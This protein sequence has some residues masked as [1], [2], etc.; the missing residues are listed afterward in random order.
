MQLQILSN[1]EVEMSLSFIAWSLPPDNQ[2]EVRLN[3]DQLQP[4]KL[5]QSPQ[6]Y[7]IKI[8]LSKGRNYLNFDTLLP[9]TTPQALGLAYSDNRKLAFA[10][11]DVQLTTLSGSK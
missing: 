5:A 9:G 1:Q 11:G 10:I 7:T 3:S 8:K 6:N 4:Q 2:L